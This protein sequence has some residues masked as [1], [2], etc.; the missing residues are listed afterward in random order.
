MKYELGITTFER[1]DCL[2]SCLKSVRRFYPDLKITVADC[3]EDPP[4]SHPLVDTYIQLPFDVGVSRGRNTIIDS[5]DSEFLMIMDDDSI[6]YRACLDEMMNPFE[7]ES[8]DLVAGHVGGNFF[9]K[10][11]IVNNILY[12][13]AG[14][15]DYVP[16]LFI[17]KTEKLREVRWN[18]D[19]KTLEHMDFFWRARGKITS[20]RVPECVFK[21]TSI[22]NKKY[23]KYRERFAEFY[24]KQC[25]AIG[26]K[27]IVDDNITQ[28]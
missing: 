4:S 19:L 6:F 18:D 23:K 8:I 17:A 12:R 1:P 14:I 9:G 2:E 28:A 15:Y 22:R 20:T 5:T 26:V 7:C 27:D 24:R 13:R 11:E 16:Q 21:N 25:D 3:S 10:L